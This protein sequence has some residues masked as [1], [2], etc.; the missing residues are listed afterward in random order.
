MKKRY[1]LLLLWILLA[2]CTQNEVFEYNYP[3][4]GIQFDYEPKNMEMSYNFSFQHD[5]DYYYGDDFQRDTINLKIALTG[6]SSNQAHSFSLKAVPLEGTDDVPLA[7]V[8]FCGPYIFKAGQLKDTIQLI[9]LRPEKRG[10]YAVGITFDLSD[11]PELEIGVK[12]RSIY[13]IHITDRYPKPTYWDDPLSKRYLGEFS[14]EKYAFFISVL[15]ILYD[16]DYIRYYGRSYNQQ[17]R[18]ALDKY[19]AEHPDAKKDFTFPQI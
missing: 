3:L 14:E 13:R 9:L 7:S 4:A 2:S 17:L 18:Q 12:E 1:D 11:T 19:N 10:E 16:Y 15:H 5:G 8:E 6:F